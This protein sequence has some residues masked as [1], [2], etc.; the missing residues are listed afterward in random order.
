MTYD[1]ILRGGRVIDPSQRLDAMSD[2]AFAGGKVAKV[3]AQAA[4]RRRHGGARRV[5]IDRDA[6]PHRPAHPCLL[7]RHLARH[8]RGGV[9]PHLRRHDLGRHRQRGPGQFRRLPQARDRAVAGAHPGLSARVA[10]RHLRLLEQRDGRRERGS[11]PD[12]PHRCRR[13]GGRQPRRDRR[14]QGARRPA[15]VGHLRRRAAAHRAGGGGRGG[16][17]ADGAHRSSPAELRGGDRDAAARRRPDAC[18]PAVSQFAV[19]RI[20]AR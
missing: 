16:H 20:R 7:G 15:C 19:R 12:G 3:G 9:L 14:H 2:V 6:G 5:G 8:R 17:A 10:R 18:V 4:G 13:G 1:L 11:A